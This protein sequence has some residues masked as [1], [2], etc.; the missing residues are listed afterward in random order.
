[1]KSVAGQGKS[2]GLWKST[3]LTEQL[4]FIPY[5]APT[6][7]DFARQGENCF[8]LRGEPDRERKCFTGAN[9]VPGRQAEQ[10]VSSVCKP[11]KGEI[12]SPGS[13]K[14]N[15]SAQPSRGR[16]TVSRAGVPGKG[17]KLFQVMRKR[18]T[19]V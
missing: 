11:E 7:I 4:N 18:Q 19:I 16:K 2:K 15:L 17:E 3:T 10:I 14:S 12:V 13:D 9:D 8:K 6:P 1:M 5:P